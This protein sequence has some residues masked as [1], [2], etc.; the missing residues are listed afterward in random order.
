MHVRLSPFREEDFAEYAS[1][2]DDAELN[3]HLGPMDQAW[4]DA[5]LA[6]TTGATYSA[7]QD[8]KLVGVIGIVYP[9]EQFPFYVITELATKPS[10]R[11]SGIGAGILDALFALH[12]LET[13]RHWKA[14]VADKNAVAK[15]FFETQGWRATGPANEAGMVTYEYQ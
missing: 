13:R 9:S 14:Y 15:A 12:P 11:R 4:L 3:T 6:L 7:F 2:F 10:L 8:D 1:W 5:T